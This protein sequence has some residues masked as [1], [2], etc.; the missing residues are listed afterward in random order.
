MVVE[1]FLVLGVQEQMVRDL[2]LRGIHDSPEGL[3][4]RLHHFAGIPV[5]CDMCEQLVRTNVN[6]AHIHVPLNVGRK[7]GILT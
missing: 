2:S 6:N 1:N 7:T 3:H 5:I 4:L